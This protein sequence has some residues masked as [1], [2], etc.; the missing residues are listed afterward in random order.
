M[1]FAFP[2]NLHDD[3][4]SYETISQALK[5]VVEEVESHAKGTKINATKFE[6]IFIGLIQNF[7]L[8]TLMGMR[9]IKK[10][11]CLLCPAANLPGHPH[12]PASTHTAYIEIGS[13]VGT[14][15]YKDFFTKIGK[16]W[17]ELGGVPH[18]CK[19]WT[20]LQHHGIFKHIHG[21][22]GDNLVKFRQVLRSLSSENSQLC[23][24]F[25]NSTMEHVLDVGETIH[26]YLIS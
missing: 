9:I 24:L 5:Y 7:P 15:T 16:K 3:G 17:M 11:D 13:F 19:Q 14:E 22:Y 8:S 12:Y 18:W 4:S 21:Y 20:F 1:E 6:F 25:I 26:S 23:K 2:F 10:S